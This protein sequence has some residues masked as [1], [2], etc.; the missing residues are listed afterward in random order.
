MERYRQIAVV[1]LSQFIHPS[2]HSFILFPSS[3]E[4]T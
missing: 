4:Y 1:S 3:S 2:I